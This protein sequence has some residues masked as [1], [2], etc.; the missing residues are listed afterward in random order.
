VHVSY[1][2]FIQKLLKAG[3]L[4]PVLKG[5]AHIT[6]GGFIDNIPRV[7]P[8]VCD[9]LIRKGSWEMPPVFELLRAKGK[10]AE[11]ELYQVFNMGIGMTL[12]VSQECAKSVLRQAKASRHKAWIIGEVTKGSG[13][14]KVQ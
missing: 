3:G 9:V 1:G 10:I 5:V 11:A 2:L 13:M 8:R 12:I 6:G 14:A 4:T 7:L